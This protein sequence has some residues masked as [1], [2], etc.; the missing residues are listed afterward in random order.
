MPA[1]RAAR[2][3]AGPCS[4]AIRSN[5]RHEPRASG[6]TSSCEEP[7]RRRGRRSLNKRTIVAGRIPHHTGPMK[8]THPAS[9]H[10]VLALL[11]LAVYVVGFFLAVPALVVLAAGSALQVHFGI[12]LAALAALAIDWVVTAAAWRRLP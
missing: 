10:G 7:R 2:M 3:T 6:V 11:C 1:S 9:A 12:T 8:S 5:V 4:R